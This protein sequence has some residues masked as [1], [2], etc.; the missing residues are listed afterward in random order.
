MNVTKATV[1]APAIWTTTTTSTPRTIPAVDECNYS[2]SWSSSYL[3]YYCITIYYYN[4]TI[5]WWMYIQQQ[6]NLQLSELLLLLYTPT[7]I[8][9]VDEC[10]YSYSWSSSYLNYYC[11]YYILL[12]LYQQLMN[13]TTATVE[14]P[15]FWTTTTTTTTLL[16]LQLYQQLMNVTTA[17]VEAPAIWTTTNIPAVDEYIYS[18]IWSCSYRNYYYY[19]Y[20]YN[21][22]ISWWI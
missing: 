19:Y 16:L 15:A 10:N 2:N 22:T 9:A 17:T 12:Q 1:E 5:S 7:T 14:A 13:V 20:S 18:N 4:Y 8:P 11:Y 21:Y 6:L 3:N